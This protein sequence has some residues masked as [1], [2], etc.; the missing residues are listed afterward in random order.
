MGT[1]KKQSRR[2]FI[3]V[4]SLSGTG[5]FLASYVPLKGM[6]ILRKGGENLFSKR[7]Y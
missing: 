7:I 4:V 2:E 1:L 5:L 3:K 6:E